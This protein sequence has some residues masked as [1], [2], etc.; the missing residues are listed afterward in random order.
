MVCLVYSQWKESL[1]MA[2]VRSETI[3]AQDQETPQED[4]HLKTT[5]WGFRFATRFSRPWILCLAA[6]VVALAL[7]LLYLGRPSIWFDEAFSVELASQP[8]PLLWHIIFGPEPN[9]E[10][11]YLLL[12]FWLRLTALAGLNPVEWVV[13]LPSAI[14]AAL[15]TGVVF[16][17]G[18]RYLGKVAASVA[19]LLY[20]CNYLQL[21][22]AQQTRSYALQLFLIC[23]SWL[24]LLHAFTSERREWRWW[25]LYA[26]SMALAVYA[27][28]FSTLVLLSQVVAIAGLFLLPGGW[29][30]QVR[31]HILIFGGSLVAIGLLCIPMWVESRQGAK[32]GWLPVPD[33]HEFLSL[34]VIIGGD[35]K[36]YLLLV[37]A[38][39]ALGLL[40]VSVALLM[41]WLSGLQR[42]AG[43]HVWVKDE[44]SMASSLLPFAWT[45]LC[46]F[47]LPIVVSYV[48]SQGSLRLFSTRYLVVV[49]P[50]LCLLAG[51]GVAIIHQKIVKIVW[52]CMLLGIALHVV[53]HYYQ[54]AQVETWR[55]AVQWM[56]VRYQPGDGLVC[57]DNAITQGCQIAVD[58]YLQAYPNGTHFPAD[59]PGAF[60]WQKYGP[61]DPAEGYQAA[62]DPSVLEAYGLH[63]PRI[64][65]IVGRV[66]NAAGA[67]QVK[68][69]EQWLNSHDHFVDQIVTSTVTIRLYS[70][71]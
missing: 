67:A 33:F 20:A 51:L 71:H 17:L 64:F 1:V 21:I 38:S 44:M 26:L 58:Y 53:P 13:R 12:H 60:S 8:L 29:R 22:Y 50:P 43:K 55:Q 25:I 32:T 65:L 7:N 69:A 54:N 41:P 4:N 30:S 42:L 36:I 48:V 2:Q 66:P 6:V 34:F 39:V 68:K 47:V 18:R 16:L 10:L 62:L 56:Q 14:F 27:H 46:W 35:N 31:K 28:L 19:A 24:A 63:H 61:A 23:I 52:S 11:Y 9:M 59:A 3:R 37:G 15:S 49:V 57:Y 40:A 45:M 70:T 5:F